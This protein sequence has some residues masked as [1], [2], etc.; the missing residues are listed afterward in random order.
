MPRLIF[1]L[2]ALRVLLV[3][4]ETLAREVEQNALSKLG[5]QNVSVAQNGAVAIDA[6]TREP[7]FDLVISDWN[8]PELDGI[9]FLKVLRQK[10]KNLPFLMITNNESNDKVQEALKAGAD[11]YII[12]PFS[13]DKLREAIHLA[14][15]AHV[16]IASQA[17]E[18]GYVSTE[19]AE[20]AEWIQRIIAPPHSAADVTARTNES[21]ALVGL[22]RLATRVSDQLDVFLNSV[23]QMQTDQ[24][25]VARLHNDCLR[26]ILSGRR[27]L[28]EHET[29]N[30]ILDALAHAADLVT[31]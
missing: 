13:L 8:M 16:E 31:V 14:L 27:D 28:L 17:T 23:G 2:S 6:I 9:N 21:D 18:K 11:G 1:D 24:I 10:Q 26:A 15:A 30:S 12:K 22:Q 7:S 5:I 20:V 29:S 4:D 19:L 3:E 25:V